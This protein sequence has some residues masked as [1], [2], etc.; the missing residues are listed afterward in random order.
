[1]WIDVCLHGQAEV[2]QK[3]IFVA[4]VKFCRARAGNENQV[5]YGE[6]IAY[7]KI[8]AVRPTVV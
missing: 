6:G 7:P 2:F 5:D 3:G 4:V 8:A 1:M